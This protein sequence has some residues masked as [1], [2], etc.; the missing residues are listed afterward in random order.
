MVNLKSNYAIQSKNAKVK[1]IEFDHMELAKKFDLEYDN[2]YLYIYF[3][4]AKYRLGMK[5]GVIQRIEENLEDNN[6][7]YI[8]AEYNEV[9]SILDLFDYSKDMPKE[10]LKLSGNFVSPKDLKGVVNGGF[11]GGGS[12]IFSKYADKFSQNIEKLEKACEKLG[13]KKINSGDVGYIIDIFKCLPF[14]FVFYD[15]DSDF[16]SEIK[17]FWDENVLNYVHYETTYFMI[18]YLFDKICELMEV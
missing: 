2:D 3:V 16:E 1:F 7:K 9:M 10:H 15:R 8:D 17:I 14:M 12:K 13:G 11:V 18:I 6:L 5:S 4:G